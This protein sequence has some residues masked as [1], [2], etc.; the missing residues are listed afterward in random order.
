[1]MK[2]YERS[3]EAQLLRFLAGR[4]AAKEAAIKAHSRRLHFQDIHILGGEDGRSAPM[5][6]GKSKPLLLVDPPRDIVWI[7]TDLAKHRGLR[8]FNDSTKL[9]GPSV[10]YYGRIDNG[11]FVEGWNDGAQRFF[12]RRTK[13]ADE[14]RQC[15]ELSITHD[16]EYAIAVCMTCTEQFN[17]EEE[18]PALVDDGSGDP[19]HDPQW[20]DEG[21]LGLTSNEPGI[22]YNNGNQMPED[23]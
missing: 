9:S 13:I 10:Y 4:W 8:G 6:P 14:D 22:P 20:G 1:M 11:I 17:D 16:G 3:S 21:F 2:G 7:P 18:K 5:D 15:A 19:L 23:V 12:K